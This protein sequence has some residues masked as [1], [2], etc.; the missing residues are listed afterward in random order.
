VSPPKSPIKFYRTPGFPKELSSL[1]QN[2]KLYYLSRPDSH[3]TFGKDSILH[4][5][6]SVVSA[7]ICHTHVFSES[8]SEEDRA[9]WFRFKNK[10]LHRRGSSDSMIIYAVSSV[11]N[12]YLL[13]FYEDGAHANLRNSNTLNQLVEYAEVAMAQKNELPMSQS[14]LRALLSA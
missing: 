5:P 11:G 9:K 7:A 4:S 13:A 3:T 10:P 6:S 12:V 1:I 8:L 2:F 14:S